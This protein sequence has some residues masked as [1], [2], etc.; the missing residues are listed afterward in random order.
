MYRNIH[1]YHY[2]F[3]LLSPGHCRF[4]NLHLPQCSDDAPMTSHKRDKTKTSAH[5]HSLSHYFL[6]STD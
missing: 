6:R 1:I 5:N 2:T 4:A 3:T